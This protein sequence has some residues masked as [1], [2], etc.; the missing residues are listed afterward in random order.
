[1]PVIYPLDR[2]AS[3]T[4]NYIVGEVQQL[5]VADKRIVVPTFSPFFT[6]NL[7]IYDNN[8]NVELIRGDD[9]ELGELHKDATMHLG[10]EVYQLLIIVNPNISGEIRI[11]YQT[12]GGDY[13]Y[14]IPA[15]QKLYDQVINRN[16][17][18]DWN[19]V[20][21][22]PDT[23]P[24]SLHTHWLS[25][26]YGFQ[27]VVDAIERVR[28]A[29]V[30]SDVPTYQAI[31][32]WIDSRMDAYPTDRHMVVPETYS[33]MKGYKLKMLY[34]TK[35][36]YNHTPFTWE[37]VHITT[38]NDDFVGLGGSFNVILDRGEFLV[39]TNNTLTTDK[40]FKVRILDNNGNEV[41]VSDPITILS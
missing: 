14:P 28:N 23:F 35:D 26:V 25:D 22:K 6:N 1:M 10:H 40:E 18:V 4:D 8:S 32:D 31:V 38:T 16:D 29:I 37:I 7:H 15:I 12:V 27:A 13:S 11:N 3:S 20:I 9:Y 39:G 5:P 34:G 30:M 19:R 41:A 2:T 17:P 21:N 36:L 24:P 33:V